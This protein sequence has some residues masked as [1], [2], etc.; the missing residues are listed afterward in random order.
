MLREK[1]TALENAINVKITELQA[2]S[3]GKRIDNNSLINKLSGIVSEID[4]I[5]NN[6]D[7]IDTGQVSGLISRIKPTRKPFT[8]DCKGLSGKVMKIQQAGQ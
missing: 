2:A 5:L 1:L 8:S 3:S 6:T 7:S 4:G